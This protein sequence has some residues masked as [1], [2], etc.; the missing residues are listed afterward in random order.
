MEKRGDGGGT[1]TLKAVKII[2]MN[3]SIFFSTIPHESQSETETKRYKKE[4]NCWLM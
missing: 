2:I 4:T 3:Q 1:G